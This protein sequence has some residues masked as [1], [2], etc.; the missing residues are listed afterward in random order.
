MPVWTYENKTIYHIH[1]P[2]T[3]G[4]IL[5]YSIQQTNQKVK[6]THKG[7]LKTNQ[8]I[9]PQH[10]DYKT[11]SKKFQLNKNNSFTVIREPWERTLSAY[12]W[13]FKK[14][15]ILATALKN[16][17]KTV[18]ENIHHK[19]NHFMPQ[20]NFISDKINV[21][22]F[23]NL[24]KLEKWIQDNFIENFK[25]LKS[26]S[27]GKVLNYTK[28]K[29]EDILDKETIDLWNKLYNEDVKLWKKYNQ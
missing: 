25:I 6:V 26:K 10:E 29:K 5:A 14:P 3:A 13:N 9:T 11:L 24:I 12:H 16:I 17:L 2:K 22:T 18:D 8:I 21:F 23:N 20:Y 4:S 28:P 27:I 1:I 15:N 7:T 19:D